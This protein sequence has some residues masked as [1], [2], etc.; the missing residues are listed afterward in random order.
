MGFS[1]PNM[2]AER[3]N[4][5]RTRFKVIKK[6]LLFF[7]NPLGLLLTKKQSFDML[8]SF[9]IYAVCKTLWQTFPLSH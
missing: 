4:P 9:G 1:I 2:T 7:K 6:R 8:I 3:N 5:R